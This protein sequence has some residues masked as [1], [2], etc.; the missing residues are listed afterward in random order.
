MYT[1][2]YIYIYIYIYPTALRER[3]FRAGRPHE[4]ARRRRVPT[5]ASSYLRIGKSLLAHCANML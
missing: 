2:I 1:Y 3:R 5:L 4:R